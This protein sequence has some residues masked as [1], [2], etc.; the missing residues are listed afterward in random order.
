MSMVLE[1]FLFY[2]ALFC[3][4]VS[5]MIFVWGILGRRRLQAWTSGLSVGAWSVVA[6]MLWRG[7]W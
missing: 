2:A 3:L 7:P 4:V 6:F 5:A 1:L